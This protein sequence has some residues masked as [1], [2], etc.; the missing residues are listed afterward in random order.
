LKPFW[1]SKPAQYSSRV[2]KKSTLLTVTDRYNYF[3]MSIIGYFSDVK[4]SLLKYSSIFSDK[5]EACRIPVGALRCS[6]RR[7]GR[8]MMDTWIQPRRDYRGVWNSSHKP[9]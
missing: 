3:F 8:P 2:R 4:K 5:H 9:V 6:C 1:S 7:D